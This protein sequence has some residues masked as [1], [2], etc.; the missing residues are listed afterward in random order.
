M[1]KNET[2]TAIILLVM[3]AIM[4]LLARGVKDICNELATLNATPK[5]VEVTKTIYVE[6]PATAE[7]PNQPLEEES[8]FNLIKEE[9]KYL[10][11]VTDEEID[12]LAR[13]IMSES[14][15][16]DIDVKYCI[17]QTVVNRVLSDKFP[18]TLTEVVYQENAYSTQDNG[19]PDGDCYKAAEWALTYQFLPRNTYYFRT[20]HYHN[21]GKP[22]VKMGNVYF[23]T[24]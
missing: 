4:L 24:D 19:D 12:L 2:L 18:D 5:T 13:V 1:K 3:S 10:I 9:S 8:N 15:I 14:S 6:V 16:C 23:S 11:D 7:L 22:L 21:F 20:D 17:G